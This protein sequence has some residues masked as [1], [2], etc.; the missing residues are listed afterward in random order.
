V[1]SRLTIGRFFDFDFGFDSDYYLRLLYLNALGILFFVF[2]DL[3]LPFICI[4]CALSRF[5]YRSFGLIHRH[6]YPTL[7][8]FTRALHL[9][10][11][12]PPPN[13]STYIPI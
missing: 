12:C 1:L 11:F 13:L 7:L 10:I 4:F 8:S 3:A 5:R 6:P 9:L 2:L